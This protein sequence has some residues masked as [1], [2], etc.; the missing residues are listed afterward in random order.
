MYC[1]YSIERAL[2]KSQLPHSDI[3]LLK[4]QAMWERKGEEIAC[5]YTKGTDQVTSKLQ[6]YEDFTALKGTAALTWS[7][8]EK[9]TA[10][11][12]FAYCS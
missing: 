10:F 3:A 1:S 5:I 11:R 12:S 2:I 8:N 4:E 7:H 6:V 9:T